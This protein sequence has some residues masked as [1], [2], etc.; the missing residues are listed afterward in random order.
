VRGLRALGVHG[1]LPEE[2]ERAQPFEVDVDLAV[3]LS[4]AGATDALADTVD[5]GSV[6]SLVA[7]VVG[8]EH[9]QLLE[10]L[11]TRI[12][13]RVLDY[14]ARI[15]AVTVTVRKLR[16]PVPVDLASVAVTVTRRSS[17][18]QDGSQ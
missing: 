18:V 1:A 8:S 11:G 9:H 12:A 4:G 5:Y 3:D 14:D 6:A 16:P 2:Q 15:E 13:D 17:S 10:R 7:G